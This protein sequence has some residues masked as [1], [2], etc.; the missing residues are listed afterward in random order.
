MSDEFES[1]YDLN[2]FAYYFL[3][4]S[5]IISYALAMNRIQ[6]TTKATKQLMRIGQPA[7]RRR[8]KNSVGRLNQ[9]PETPNIKRL[10]NHSSEYRLRGGNYRVLFNH[11]AEIHIIHIEEVKKH[12]ERT[13]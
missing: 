7:T 12:D 4:L 8:I 3:A 2:P 5:Y 6:W 13:Y 11:D 10:K 9:F 1:I